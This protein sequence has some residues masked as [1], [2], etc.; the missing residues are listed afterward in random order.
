M[1]HQF[2]QESLGIDERL[3]LAAGGF[4]PGIEATGP[5]FPWS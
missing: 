1:D 4:L 3:A 5:L 2:R